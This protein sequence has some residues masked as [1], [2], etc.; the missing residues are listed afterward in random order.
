[1]SFLQFH[2]NGSLNRN[3]AQSVRPSDECLER[4]YE[5]LQKQTELL[6][7]IQTAQNLQTPLQ[8]T[9]AFSST[10]L[11][12]QSFGSPSQ[13]AQQQNVKK[14]CFQCG[15]FGHLKFQCYLNPNNG[16]NNNRRNIV[17][18][19]CSKPGHL[20]KDCYARINYEKSQEGSN[21]NNQAKQF[22]KNH[23]ENNPRINAL[24]KNTKPENFENSKQDSATSDVQVAPAVLPDE[25]CKQDMLTVNIE[26]ESVG[27]QQTT[28]DIPDPDE[29]LF[30][31]NPGLQQNDDVHKD[32]MIKIRLAD[33]FVDAL[34]DTGAAI[35]VLNA[36]V[37]SGNNFSPSVEESPTENIVTVSGEKLPI[38]GMVR[39]P[40]EIGNKSY[41][42]ELQVVENFSYDLVLGKDFLCK[43]N[44]I[45]DLKEGKLQLSGSD[46]IPLSRNSSTVHVLRTVV[47]QPRSQ[48]IIPVKLREPMPENIVGLIES[49]SRLGE[50]YRLAGAAE[51]VKVSANNTVP[52]RIL[53]PNTLPVTLYRN[54]N[55]GEFTELGED[56]K[57]FSLDEDLD[58]D[59][60]VVN[61]DIEPDDNPEEVPVDWTNSELSEEQQ[62]RLKQLLSSYSDVFCDKI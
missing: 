41:D 43:N 59:P 47:I 1:M 33:R 16:R 23:I 24:S 34:V 42:T 46:S 57:A 40:I 29:K 37:L 13:Q 15:K 36:S 14:Q 62:L 26:S 54:T 45:I 27:S 4:L 32:L 50:R 35:T 60:A 44:A 8:P 2:T 30:T 10:P 56:V 53:N 18:H 12:F 55:L 5:N 28:S 20:K 7:Q 49:N 58:T 17:C 25:I 6:T 9:Q 51:L 38:L 21:N 52:F 39:L 31:I 22:D 61:N 3:L 11:H 19:F 48:V